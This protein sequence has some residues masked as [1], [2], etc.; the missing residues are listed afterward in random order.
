MKKSAHGN[1]IFISHGKTKALTRISGFSEK[2]IQ[3]LIFNHPDCLPISDIDEVYNPIIPICL[4][5]WTPVGP[6]DIFMITP[7]GDLVI[8]E[9]K[10]WYNP[11][12]RRKVVAQVLDY[13]KEISKW[14]YSDLQREISRKTELKGNSLYKLVAQARPNQILSEADFVDSVSR[15]LRIGRFLLLIV[16]DGIRE[17]AKGISEFLNKSGSLNFT[18][19][20]IEMPVYESEENVVIV[21]PRTALKTVEI[22]K[23]NIEVAEGFRVI[24]DSKEL[25]V[26]ASQKEI[27]KETYQR[28]EFFTSFWEEYIGQ[29]N[30]DDPGQLLPKSTKTQN[31]YLYPGLDK[32][33]WISAFFSQSTGRVGVYYRFHSNQNG[34]LIK[35]RLSPYIEEIKTELGAKVSWSWNDNM[36]KAFGVILSVRDVY[37]PTNKNQ[38]F[39]FFNLWINKFVNVIRPRLRQIE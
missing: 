30:L 16:G 6:L 21:F 32:S 24:E 35:E 12:A 20:M 31:L 14:A 18:L 15:N 22:Q 36:N 17:G 27:S 13:A 7:N 26:G 33:T 39:E 25:I 37:D 10:L 23:I 29:L 3:D 2:Q 5:L 1:P 34:Q 8:I 4:E 9:T 28:R 19:A 11:E 38:I